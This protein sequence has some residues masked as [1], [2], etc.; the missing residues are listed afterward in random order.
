MVS[1]STPLMDAGEGLIRKVGLDGI[2]NTFPI[3]VQLGFSMKLAFTPSGELLVAETGAG[4]IRAIE[5]HGSSKTI[6][7]GGSVI[8]A[9]EVLA[10]E[11]SITPYSVVYTSKFSIL[12]SDWNSRVYQLYGKCFGIDYFKGVSGHGTCVGEDQCQCDEWMGIDCS[13]THCFSVT[14]HLPGVV[15]SGRGKCVRPN[16]CLCDKGFKGHKCHIPVFD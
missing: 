13:I 12:C 11:A 8:G 4:N 5:K 2:I 14:S 3:D 15:C 16:K 6:A 7:G 9:H 10:T 1:P